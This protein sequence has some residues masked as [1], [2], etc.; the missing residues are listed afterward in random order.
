M[1]FIQGNFVDKYD[2]TVED[3]Y[4]KVIDV[5]GITCMLD[6]MDTAGQVGFFSSFSKQKFS[7]ILL[8]DINNRKNTVYFVTNTSKLGKDSC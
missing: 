5:D 6:I 3:S 7:I 1:R 4:S 8:N 2:P